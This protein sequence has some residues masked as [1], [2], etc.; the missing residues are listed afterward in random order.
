MAHAGRSALEMDKYNTI[1][2]RF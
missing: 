1:S 2:G